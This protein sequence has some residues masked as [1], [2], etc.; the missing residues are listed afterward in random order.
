MAQTRPRKILLLNLASMISLPQ[1]GSS[2]RKDVK[3]EEPVILLRGFSKID[4]VANDITANISADI[5]TVS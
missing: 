4:W 3:Y 2:A 5:S 1:T